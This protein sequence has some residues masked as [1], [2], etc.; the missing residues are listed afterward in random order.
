MS[1]QLRA[2]ANSNAAGGFLIDPDQEL[3]IRGIGRITA[4]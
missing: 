1:P 4:N 3:L 2:K